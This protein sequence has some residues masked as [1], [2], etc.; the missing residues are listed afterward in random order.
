M[1][2]GRLLHWVAL[3]ALVLGVC[4]M[5]PHSAYAGG[6]EGTA[7]AAKPAAAAP[8]AP[9]GGS[10]SS[11]TWTG[12]Y[13]GANLGYGWGNGDAF[14]NPLPTAAVFVNLLPQTLHTDPRGVVGGGQVGYNHQHG[15]FVLGVETDLQGTGMRGTKFVTP[16]V[17]NNGTPFP[18]AGFVTAHE[19]T[20]WLGTLRG[21]VGVA[22]WTKVLLYGTGGLA[23]GHVDYGA[24]TDFIPVGTETYPVT[25][26]R[27][28]AGWIGGGGGE[29]SIHPR[30]SIKA[31]YLHYDLGSESMTA[32]PIPPFPPAA[33]PFQVAYRW[34]TTGNVVR[35]G[36][37]FHF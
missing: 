19:T 30:V 13:V 5:L 8:A 36:I 28:K 7:P 23:Y 24:T 29:V 18:G 12:F 31:E 1:K 6:P 35:G 27:T 34:Q 14:V 3:G 25:F 16:I 4:A 10:S 15:F 17:Q 33:P 37:N 20:S 11:F 22:P 21:R 26:N 9:S 2:T 32:N